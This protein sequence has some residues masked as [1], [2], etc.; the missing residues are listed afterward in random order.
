M[1]S[2]IETMRKLLDGLYEE[3]EENESKVRKDGL[4][5]SDFCDDHSLPENHLCPGLPKRS[6]NTHQKIRA[7]KTQ[8]NKSRITLRKIAIIVFIIV[9]IAII[10][11][12]YTKPFWCAFNL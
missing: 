5:S 8:Y 2:P 4:V 9:V 1:S 10:L 11:Y 12:L 3:V 6:W 7:S